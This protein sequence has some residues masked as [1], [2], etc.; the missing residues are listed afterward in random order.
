[1]R[2]YI[3]GITFLLIFQISKAQCPGCI[4]NPN[5]SASPAQPTLCPSVLP[6]GTQ[7]QTYDENIT[8][9]MPA[10]FQ[11]QGIN[12]TLNK[13]TVTN[14]SGMPPGI[15]WE[16]SA[17][18]SNIFFP[19]SNPPTSER[20]C[21][22]MCGV[23]TLF[24]LY[25]II[26]S[27]TAE[28]STPLG[29]ITQSE[30]FSIPIN[31]LPPPGGNATFTYNPSFGCSPL[32]VTFNATLQ[33][34]AMEE[35]TYQWDFDNGNTSDLQTPP[36]QSYAVADTYYVSLTTKKFK[37]RLSSVTVT[38]TGTNWCGDVEEPSLFGVCTGSPDMYFEFTNSGATLTSPTIDDQM[39]ATFS[40]LNYIL[41]DPVLSLHFF[42][43]DL[44]SANDD[45][46]NFLYTVTGAGT[47]N[48]STNQVSGSF[49][50]D[51]VFNQQFTDIDTVIVFP[52]PAV[53]IITA[54][55]NT[56][57]CQGDSVTLS[58]PS[59]AGSN[60]QWYLNDTILMFGNTMP[61]LTINTAGNYSVTETNQFG[62][63]NSSVNET[64]VVYALP[65]SPNLMVSGGE[66]ISGASGNLQWYF[67]GTPISG[68]TQSTL[69]YADTGM[70]MLSVT[71]ADGCINSS[72]IY[73][74]TPSGLYAVQQSGSFSVYPNPAKDVLMIKSSKQIGNEYTP[75]TIYDVNG[76]EVYH[77]Y[78]NLNSKST[79]YIDI[80]ELHNG[81]YFIRIKDG[82]IYMQQ[83][84]AILK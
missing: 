83:K 76:K 61:D 50:I 55:G 84:I 75:V 3:L 53:P 5:C 72:S 4:V 20:G 42:D 44:V 74:N 49:T 73:I 2:K 24:G 33:P 51:T 56:S 52:T 79:E 36:I 82:H 27:V 65:P 13:I 60:Y 39:T 12:V 9:Y 71:S 78:L 68:A 59:N 66:I 8:F 81:L 57:F 62:C 16:T 58:V 35:L 80:S 29:N 43:E 22:K 54:S 28:V 21:V 45:L 69:L 46:G 63:N 10:Q 77:Q 14:I 48:L 26:V 25:N 67:N 18:P 31:I 37:Y 1:M 30:S 47:F 41:T 23:P 40:N 11:A 38:A 15:N 6:D 70:Y 34:Q 64:V 17:S 19:S 32:D 7:N